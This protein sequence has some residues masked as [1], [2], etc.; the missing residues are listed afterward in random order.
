MAEEG[1]TTGTLRLVPA[2][3]TK[4]PTAAGPAVGGVGL[5]RTHD[6]QE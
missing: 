4:G 5:W 6:L 2:E 1:R 3:A